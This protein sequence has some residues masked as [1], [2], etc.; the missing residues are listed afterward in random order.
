[1]YVC[2]DLEPGHVVKNSKN[3]KKKSRFYQ[4][5]N[6]CLVEVYLCHLAQLLYVFSNKKV[7]HLN[8]CH[9]IFSLYFTS[10]LGQNTILS[11][12]YAFCYH[13]KIFTV[14]KKKHFF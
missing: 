5:S 13:R 12:I 2:V 8:S 6:H 9:K 10:F 11:T 4:I 1:M 14:R 3:N 7:A